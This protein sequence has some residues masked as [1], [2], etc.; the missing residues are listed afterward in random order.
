MKEYRRDFVM[1][2]FEETLLE[3]ADKNENIVA[4][5]DDL[6][7]CVGVGEFS[8]KYPERYA[9][10]GI[11]EQ[12][13]VGVAAGLASCG[14]TAVV[15]SFANFSILRPY[16]QVRNDVSYTNFNVKV[17]GTVSGV[18][19]PA[20]GASHQCFEDIAVSRV[21]PN[22]R[23]LVP[24]DAPSIRKA[25]KL[26]LEE[27]G[28]VYMRFGRDDEYVVYENDDF[29][30][31]YGGSNILRRGTDIALIA[32]G[33]M[34]HVAQVAAELLE[35]AGISATVLDLYSIKPIDAETLKEL[36]ATHK[37]MLTIEE[38]YVAGGMGS[39]VLEALSQTGHP[40]L[41]MMGFQDQYPDIGNK[42]DLVRERAG[43]SPEAAAE[44]ARR[45]LD[46]IK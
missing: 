44:Q 15:S 17:I 1:P 35:E 30:I 46:Q 45:L 40:P 39:A 27:E 23:V 3:A 16:E 13:M 24:A 10:L 20:G 37:A 42:A 34:V 41:A 43:L 31:R 11:A 32:C 21:L 28:P 22:F 6:G 19:F 29:E 26:I 25:T 14:K 2:A 9:D 33:H 5:T 38:H 7:R 36:A 18:T 4:L 12:N 8:K